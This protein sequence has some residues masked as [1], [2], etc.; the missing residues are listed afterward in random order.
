MKTLI[1]YESKH[2]ATKKV[3]EMLGEKIENSVV[4]RI[5][6]FVGDLNKYEHVI[7]GGPIYLGRLS[8]VVKEYIKDNDRHINAAF[9]SGMRHEESEKEIRDNFSREFL[10]DKQ[11]EFVGGA[12]NFD[13]LSL[14]EKLAVKVVSKVRESKEE[15][16]MESIN[17][18]VKRA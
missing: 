15:F 1:L 8:P 2:G 4:A 12:F 6:N 14:F 9:V 11:V 7:V 17:R 16:D 18:L 13:S 3:A 5:Q 10:T